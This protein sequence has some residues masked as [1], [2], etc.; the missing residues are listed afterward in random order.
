MAAFVSVAR[1]LTALHLYIHNIYDLFHSTFLTTI[2]G[3]L[4]IH[5]SQLI[6]I[7]RKYHILN[8]ILQERKLQ[9][10]LNNIIVFSLIMEL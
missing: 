9:T 4:F 7:N 5:N 8:R 10:I 6:K 3:N 2:I 1:A